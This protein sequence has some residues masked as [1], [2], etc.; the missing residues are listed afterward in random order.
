MENASTLP[1]VILAIGYMFCW[2]FFLS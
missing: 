2:C 1:T